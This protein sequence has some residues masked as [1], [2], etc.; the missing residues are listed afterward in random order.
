MIV[1][2]FVISAIVITAFFYV[3]TIQKTSQFGILKAI[4]TKN[5]QLISS[6][7]IQILIITLIGVAIAIAIILGLNT[8]MP[9]T[10]P[11][12]L[13]TNLMLLMVGVFIIVS[14]IGAVLSLIKVMKIEPLEAI[15]GE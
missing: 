8:V 5:K 10:M 4:G 11:F 13:N 15:G 3:M 12:Y 2:L 7:M 9:V 14:L 6:L 1:F